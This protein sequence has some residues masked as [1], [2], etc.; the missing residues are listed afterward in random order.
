MT[1]GG[2]TDTIDAATLAQHVEPLRKSALVAGVAGGVALVS[3]GLLGEGWPAF[4]RAY[5]I[6]ILF[7]LSFAVGGLGWVMLHNLTGGLWG[8]VTQRIMESAS[9][10]LPVL[11]LLFLPVLVGVPY[12]YEWADPAR[13]A[14]SKLLLHKSAYLNV[15]FFS[16][17]AVAYLCLWSVLATI[18][19]LWSRTRDAGGE[20]GERAREAAGRL[21]APGLALLVLTATFAGIDW[22]M[23]LDPKWSS[24]AY[25]LTYMLGGVLAALALN[26]LLLAYLARLDA[27]ARA[28]SP[29]HVNDLG[30][31]MLGF[32]M[33]WMYVS[34]SQFLIIWSGDI[35]EEVTWYLFRVEGGWRALAIVIALIHFAIPFLVLISRANKR[36]LPV[37]VRVAALLL[38]ARLA[39]FLW[40]V[41]PNF[42]RTG[43]G[44]GM[45]DFFAP[46]ALGG[47]SLWLL[48]GFLAERP[49]ALGVGL[50][51]V[52]HFEHEHGSAP[53]GHAGAGHPAP[54]HGPATTEGSA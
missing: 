52:A 48:L 21:S 20:E 51:A 17:R 30:N 46:L 7:C 36:R 34:F 37:L 45:A 29:I 23:S 54:P 32:V 1:G 16:A 4:L 38:V 2:H 8:F 44:L 24:A 18:L 9:R 27:L 19:A 42:A 26:V 3:V 53:G 43:P 13:V 31:L 39:D 6:G 25:G 15:W 49:L 28:L 41:V 14:A 50:S 11:A 47:L 5:L 10:T 35:P 22:L 40:Q 33:F 12:L